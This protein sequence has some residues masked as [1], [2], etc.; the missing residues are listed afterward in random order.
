MSKELF[1]EL[2]VLSSKRMGEFAFRKIPEQFIEN[3]VA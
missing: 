3:S 2:E 1:E